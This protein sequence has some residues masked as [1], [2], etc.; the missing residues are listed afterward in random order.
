MHDELFLSHA[1]RIITGFPEHAAGYLLPEIG[2]VDADVADRLIRQLLPLRPDGLADA[3]RPLLEQP[4][5]HL[6]ATAL[7]TLIALEDASVR[8]FI[9]AALRSSNPRL[10]A[11]GIHGLVIIAGRPAHRDAMPAW[12]GLLQGTVEEQQAALSL[13]AELERLRGEER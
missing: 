1:G 11:A 4:D 12:E 9:D 3:V 7:R 6:Q 10:R 8:T 2:Q 13:F 5:T